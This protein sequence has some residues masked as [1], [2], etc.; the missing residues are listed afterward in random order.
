MRRNKSV[1]K[2][3]KRHKILTHSTKVDKSHRNSLSLLSKL[4]SPSR[5]YNSST[6]QSNIFQSNL[7]N[8]IISLAN[9]YLSNS[10]T[11][12]IA[13][14][15][16]RDNSTPTS[17]S[18]TCNLRG[19]P[20]NSEW[21]NNSYYLS[22][23]FYLCFSWQMLAFISFC[24]PHCITFPASKCSLF[25]EKN[26]LQRDSSFLTKNCF[27]GV[28]KNRKL[29]IT[30]N[31]SKINLQWIKF[32]L[33]SKRYLFEWIK[34]KKITRNMQGTVRYNYYCWYFLRT[35]KDI[36]VKLLDLNL[37]FQESAFIHSRK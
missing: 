5:G 10:S 9:M 28:F 8:C 36:N 24:S 26:F 1:H 35:F 11:A 12:I 25:R 31:L 7:R 4:F 30:L 19:Y 20:Y 16:Q 23:H 22:F 21:T 27:L 17:T 32:G 6:Q 34:L 13:S 29:K 2:T 14:K 18:I 3:K 15:N 33:F 37:F